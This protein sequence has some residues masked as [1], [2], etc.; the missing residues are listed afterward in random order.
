MEI[1]LVVCVVLLYLSL[2]A[3]ALWDANNNKKVAD[4]AWKLSLRNQDKLIHL[5]KYF[6]ITYAKKD[7]SYPKYVKEEE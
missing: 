5:E 6:K 1:L 2:L 4:R 3:L 7:Y